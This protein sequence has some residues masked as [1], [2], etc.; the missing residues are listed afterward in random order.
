MYRT[1]R[2]ILATFVVV[3]TG[4]ALP[5]L[6]HASDP[7]K[8][9]IQLS[10]GAYNVTEEE[11]VAEIQVTRTGTPARLAMPAHVYFGTTPD[12]ARKNVRFRSVPPTRHDFAPGETSFTFR[13]GL[14]DDPIHE[15]TQRFFVSIFGNDYGSTLGEN[16]KAAVNVS[17]RD[18]TLQP[19]LDPINPLNIMGLQGANPLLGVERL[20]FVDQRYGLASRAQAASARHAR[21]AEAGLLNRIAR[22][23]ETHRFGSFDGG[24]ANIHRKVAEF[25]NRTFRTSPGSIPTMATYRLL[26]VNCG[27]SDGGG[28]RELARYQRW[29]DGF[30]AG[31]GNFPVV[32]FHEIDASITLHCLSP[33]AQQRRMEMMRYAVAKL[34]ALPHTVVYIDAGAADGPY[35]AAQQAKILRGY[36]VDKAQGFF[37]NATHYDWT[38]SEIRFGRKVSSLVGGKHFVVNTAVNGRGPLRPKNRV[39]NG[40][41]VRCN[42]PGRGL[43]HAPSTRTGDRLVDAFW[44]IG[45]PGRSTGACGHG[46]P[47]TGVWFREYALGLA[48]RAALSSTR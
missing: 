15:P 14:L 13:V 12:S 30:A 4:G 48:K 22:Y 33:A 18:A 32:V 39:K 29:I 6:V 34:T 43:G 41:E 31:I 44:W 5:A 47:A 20:A 8:G 42:P 1:A 45:N 9:S 3:L 28:T 16:A 19:R 25:L 2:L 24:P 27:N 26:H 11:K 17:D 21:R 36:G 35:T 40:N 46:D 38:Q 7:P 10:L 37:L 23:P